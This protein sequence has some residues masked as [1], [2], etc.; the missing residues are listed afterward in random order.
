M[1]RF[2]LLSLCML[3]FLWAGM[4]MA[5]DSFFDIFWVVLGGDELNWNHVVDGGGSGYVDPTGRQ[6]FYYEAPPGTIQTDPW[7]RINPRPSWQNIW[8][9]DGRL[10]PGYKEVIIKFDYLLWD[11]NRNGGTDIVINWSTPDWVSPNPSEPSPPMDNAYIGRATINDACWLEAGTGGVYSF[12]GRYDLRDYG[13]NYNPE[14]VSID[15]LGYNVVLSNPNA[16]GSIEH[17][18]VPEPSTL[19][20]LVLAG[21]GCYV[22][23]RWK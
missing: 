6:W 1:R 13:V 8:F 4:A 11:I 19:T 10:R 9:Y 18:C 2:F 3:V 12:S 23:Q 17:T 16:P 14:W 21:L 7:G 5:Q 15:V 22:W 20:L